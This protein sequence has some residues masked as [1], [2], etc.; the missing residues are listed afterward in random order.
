MKKVTAI[1]LLLASVATCA[2]ADVGLLSFPEGSVEDYA[3]TEPNAR[4]LL[5]VS[6]FSNGS[7]ET[8]TAEGDKSVSVWKT[9]RI[10]TTRLSGLL[11]DQLRESGYEV[12]F[13]CQTRDCGGFDF[14]FALDVVGEPLMH[15][16]L[17]DYRYIT[18]RHG[19]GEDARLI[20]VLISRSPIKGFV[21]ITSVAKGEEAA[22]IVT[23]STKLGEAE[24][25]SPKLS[26]SESL[27]QN[28][29]AVLEGLIFS[30]GASGLD[31]S[32]TQSLSDLAK[33]LAEN[34]T[35][36]VILVGH[37]DASGTLDGNVLLSRKR[38]LSVVKRL[39]DTYGVSP[40]QLTSEGVGYLSPRA[41][42]ATK[43]G[44]DL[45]RRVE[46]VLTSMD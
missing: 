23:V 31:E 6:A 15:V 14:R 2:I 17:G 40:K 41:S 21:Q 46:V 37:T 12:L 9:P 25:I 26:L 27:M 33:F 45:N 42:N 7:F 30:Q 16:D 20:G 5:P 35:K 22:P 18:A 10:T 38:A 34:P 44:R 11:R 32:T 28:G 3:V 39:V 29:S 43:E 1:S 8:E 4:V 13:E 36:T 24:D 19:D